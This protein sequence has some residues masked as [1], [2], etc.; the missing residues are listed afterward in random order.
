MNSD[1]TQFHL[2]GLIRHRFW[3][4]PLV[5]TTML[6]YLFMFVFRSQA[7][8]VLRH[9]IEDVSAQVVRILVAFHPPAI[10]FKKEDVSDLEIYPISCFF[11]LKQKYM[12]FLFVFCPTLN[13]W[14]CRSAS[15]LTRY[16]ARCFKRVVET[17][18]TDLLVS[19][20]LQS[21]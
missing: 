6:V 8:V 20:V 19:H 15:V 3:M 18:V 12:V 9:F 21:R 13:E 5:K 4:P 14:E 7:V 1:E 11:T 17:L 16:L 2:L 10:E